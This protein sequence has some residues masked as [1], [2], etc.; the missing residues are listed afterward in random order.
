MKRILSLAAVAALSVAAFADDTADMKA[1]L[2][3]LKSQIAELKKNQETINLGDLAKQVKELK[4]RTGGDNVKWDIDYRA[5]YDNINYKMTGAAAY[6]SE[7]MAAML[8]TVVYNMAK[9]FPGGATPAN[10]GAAYNALMG[11]MPAMAK[12]PILG[13]GPDNASNAALVT[14][15][16]I[17]GMKAAPT[18][19]LSFIGKLSV[20]KA[21]GDSANHSQS[22]VAAGA[23]YSNFDWIAN[24]NALDSTVR[25]KE[26]Y[27][28]YFGDLG[29]V[30]YT[31]SIGRRP[32]YDGAPGNMREGNANAN[33]PLSHLINMEYDGASFLF[34]LEKV[35]GV[36][37]MS[38]KLC[39]GKGLTNA[40]PRFD[41]M[42]TGA[43][44]SKDKTLNGD[45][46]LYGFI[47]VPYDNGQYSVHSM[48]FKANNM[49]GFDQGDI[50]NF[51]RAYGS[52][53]SSNYNMLLDIY[54][55]GNGA[56]SVVNNYNTFTGMQNLGNA[57]SK[58]QFRNV[59]AMN[60]GTVYA[61][62]NGIG[63]GL[64]DFFDNTTAF[65]S[66]AFTKTMP[67]GGHNMLGSASSK[68]GSSWYAGVQMPLMLTS[69]GRLGLELNQGS[70]YWRSMTYGEDT[71]IGSKIA[72]R[73]KAVEAYI[74]QPLLKNLDSQLRFTRIDYKYT[75]SNGFFGAEGTPNDIDQ[76]V[77]G[78]NAVKSATDIRAYLRYRY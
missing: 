25:L 28:I 43:D 52:Y 67:G 74:T 32:S 30:P 9:G 34:N 37:G 41:M 36:T 58:L 53:Y 27:A 35:T 64:G 16:L 38:W 70:K 19:D 56:G 15:R 46:D 61:M 63:T 5:S 57:A 18:K 71:M 54:S 29:D 76:N 50:D 6:Q 66:Y 10:Q 1:E 72:A 51:H 75:G 33:S 78:T 14:N 21:F 45:I 60:G 68:F 2:Q 7:S 39:M 49:I 3:A 26:A 24:E 77:D 47:F 22:N 65:A 11:M 23:G 73:G 13:K 62:A 40:V 69:E 8:P 42:H 17:L 12:D 4:L 20:N 31:A 55:G 59:G 48:F 44:Y